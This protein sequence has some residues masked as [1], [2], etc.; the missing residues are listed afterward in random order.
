MILDNIKNI[1]NYKGLSENIDTAIDFLLQNNF[2]DV[3]VGKYYI[4]GENV[5]YMIQEY[6]TKKIEDGKFEVHKKYIDIQYVVKGQE[7]IGYSPVEHLSPIGEY[8]EVKDKLILKGSEELHSLDEGMFGIYFPND[9]HK[10]SINSSKTKVK[11][12]VVKIKI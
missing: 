1:K 8:D 4:D 6:E 3:E 2:S 11:K 5:Y 9:G 7:L 12:V 10:P